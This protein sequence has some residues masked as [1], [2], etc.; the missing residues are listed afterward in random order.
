V[1]PQRTTGF[2]EGLCRYGFMA[3]VSSPHV[4]SRSAGFI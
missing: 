4:T 1:A 3:G 2:D